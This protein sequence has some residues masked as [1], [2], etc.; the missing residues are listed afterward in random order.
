MFPSNLIL[1][2]VTGGYAF[3]VANWEPIL[4]IGLPIAL[5]FIGKT[6]DV[7]VKVYLTKNQK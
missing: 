6:V 7:A 3:F 4:T 5:F 1:S 2:S